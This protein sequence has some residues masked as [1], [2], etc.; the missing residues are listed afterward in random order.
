LIFTAQLILGEEKGGAKIDDILA[1][2]PVVRELK[3]LMKY[4]AYTLLDST[5]IR[6]IDKKRAY[7]V[8]GKDGNMGLEL[9]P[10]F[11]RDEQQGAIQ[12]DMRLVQIHERPA[13]INKEVTIAP[14]E[15]PKGD[16]HVEPISKDHAGKD[17]AAETEK[18]LIDTNLIIKPGERTVVGVS[19]L[20]GGDKG[21]ILIIS[22]KI[23][24]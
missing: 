13:I 4:Q 3:G 21:L 15:K 22:A 11:I 20:D 14:A 24:S 17:N 6:T 1:G 19:R 8:F 23:V 9:R 5:V 10:R 2:D 12:L 18:P 16:W 7:V